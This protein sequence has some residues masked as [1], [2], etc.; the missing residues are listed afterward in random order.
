MDYQHAKR[1]LTAYE[2]ASPRERR[3]VDESPTAAPLYR[4]ARIVVMVVEEDDPPITWRNLVNLVGVRAARRLSEHRLNRG[5]SRIAPGLIMSETPV[6]SFAAAQCTGPEPKAN[7]RRTTGSW[8]RQTLHDLSDARCRKSWVHHPMFDE[9]RATAQEWIAAKTKPADAP[10]QIFHLV[11]KHYQQIDRHIVNFVGAGGLDRPAKTLRET[12]AQVL[13]VVGDADGKLRAK[14][15]ADLSARNA[16]GQ[17]TVRFSGV[18]GS[19]IRAFVFLALLDERVSG[20][21]V[22]RFLHRDHSSICHMHVKAVEDPLAMRIAEGV[23]AAFGKPKLWTDRTSVQ[24]PNQG[25]RRKAIRA[26]LG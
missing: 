15:S 10:Y 6:S 14:F 26:A 4:T 24:P 18:S 21:S 11:R 5:L 7:T 2:N 23:I 17:P 1:L 20:S 22:G 13:N 19:V 12:L 16:S 25:E 8:E 3:E 9:A